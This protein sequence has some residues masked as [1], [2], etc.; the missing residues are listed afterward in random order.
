MNNRRCSYNFAVS[1]SSSA[2]PSIV[3]SKISCHAS[4][5]QISFPG[6]ILPVSSIKVPMIFGF[7]ERVT[8]FKQLRHFVLKELL[9][10]GTPQLKD[11]QKKK[12]LECEKSYHSA[13]ISMCL[14]CSVTKGNSMIVTLTK[15]EK[16]MCGLLRALHMRV[17]Q[18]IC[19]RITGG[20]LPLIDLAQCEKYPIHTVLA[21]FQIPYTIWKLENRRFLLRKRS[22][23]SS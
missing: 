9:K 17:G 14:R 19:R 22:S 10:I 11:C 7:G 4:S 5:C 16:T 18:T 15:P 6:A 2:I 1:R 3:L 21:S 20:D 23:M 8:S 12:W 13:H